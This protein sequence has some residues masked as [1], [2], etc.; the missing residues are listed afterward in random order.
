MA[1]RR[2]R[3]RRANTRMMESIVV[4][5]VS[6]IHAEEN[7]AAKNVIF[8]TF[9]MERTDT[10]YATSEVSGIVQWLPITCYS[11]HIPL[12]YN[13]NKIHVIINIARRCGACL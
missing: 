4:A 10:T 11:L 3:G 7:A 13:N 8:A 2:A 12:H 9:S 6:V 1:R 5:T